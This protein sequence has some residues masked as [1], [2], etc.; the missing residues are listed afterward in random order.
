MEFRLGC[1]GLVLLARF[2]AAFLRYFDRSAS[3]ALRSFWLALPVFP[4]FLWQVWVAMRE[5]VVDTAY[6]LAARSVGYAYGWIL[7]PLF[8]L[9]AA[10]TLE[11]DREGP[12]CIAVYNWMSLIWVILQLPATILAG[13]EPDS[14]V[15]TGL[16][17]AAFFF[18]LALEGFMLM[19]CLRIVLWQA[20]LLV[21]V[22]VGISVV[23]IVPATQVLG[24]AP[25]A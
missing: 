22:D 5:P 19:Q 8:L 24:C 12:G 25:L 1:R 11:R 9:W 6:C 20:A 16:D 2:D 13:F 21:A 3:G 10:H 14:A 15:A 18:S 23:L 4:F 17:I 7:F